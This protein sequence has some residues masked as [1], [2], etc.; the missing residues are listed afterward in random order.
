[1]GVRTS[2]PPDKRSCP[3]KYGRPRS[4][5]TRPQPLVMARQKQPPAS[6]P[7]SAGAPDA[8]ALRALARPTE[9]TQASSGARCVPAL[10]V[11]EGSR[12]RADVTRT[13][14]YSSS[15]TALRALP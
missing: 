12:Q 2:K 14:A 6:M 5:R 15:P 10:R 13:G 11:S 3:A 8:A 4:P 7:A 1:M 9:S